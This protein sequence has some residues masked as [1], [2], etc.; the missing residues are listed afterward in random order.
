MTQGNSIEH[1]NTERQVQ[2]GIES[3]NSSS[4]SNRTEKTAILPLAN[5]YQLVHSQLMAN[6]KV[7][8]YQGVTQEASHDG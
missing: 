7:S 4:I 8:H 5:Q 2:K 3:Q 1:M 6:K